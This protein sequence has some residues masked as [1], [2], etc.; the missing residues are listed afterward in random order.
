MALRF[1]TV[2]VVSHDGLVRAH[3][4]D[5]TVVGPWTTCATST[6][7]P[8]T[9]I[10]PLRDP[11]VVA[12]ADG[13][14]GHPAGDVASSVVVQT[15]AGLGPTLADADAVRQAL[16]LCN[17]RLFEAA[18]HDAARVGMGTTVAGVVMGS[19]TAMVFNIGDSRV[20]VHGPEG[21]DLL[22]VDDSPPLA[23]GETHTVVVTQILGGYAAEPVYPHISRHMI[24]EQQR[25]VVC[26]DGLSDV[27][28]HPEIDR[29]LRRA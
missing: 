25:L 3:N 1:A 16:A 19:E 8:Q 11:L 7:A 5:S 2:T 12:V 4:E 24:D 26:S 21:L 23:P 15:L 6:L 14:G 27:V 28:P 17:E 29:V 10:F 22:S 9:F 18:A 13:L 20:Y